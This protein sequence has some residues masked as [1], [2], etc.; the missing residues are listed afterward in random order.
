MG[1][2]NEGLTGKSVQHH[3]ILIERSFYL[4]DDVVAIARE[5]IGKY[6]YTNID[7]QFTGGLISETEAYNG[8]IDRASHAWNGRRTRRTEIMYQKG[9]IAYVYLCYGIHSLFNV[10]T[11]Q[12]N[13]PHAVLIRSII[14]VEG[15][16]FMTERSGLKRKTRNMG[17]GPGRVSKILGIHYSH[18]GLDIS[19]DFS[20]QSMGKSGDDPFIGIEDRGIEPPDDEIEVTTRIGVDYA[21]EDA[22]LPYRFVWTKKTL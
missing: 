3:Q 22:L 20:H 16:E 19:Y 14:P 7:G 11:N 9:G 13:I 2:D 15:I 17:T 21:A 8:I 18:S 1:N 12:E 6:L 10:V 5:L 4:R